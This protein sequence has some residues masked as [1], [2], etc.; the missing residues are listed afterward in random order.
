MIDKRRK[1][2]KVQRFSGH[3]QT[4]CCGP[5]DLAHLAASASGLSSSFHC[6]TCRFLRHVPPC[7]SSVPAFFQLLKMSGAPQSSSCTAANDTQRP[8]PLPRPHPEKAPS[9]G[10][11][12]ARLPALRTMAS[13]V[14]GSQ[15]Q[16]D[17]ALDH[18][19]FNYTLM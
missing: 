3:S 18:F 10:P 1:K 13:T 8:T 4:K 6:G 2:K 15:S 14:G 19:H 9:R 11:F 17:G 7:L 5:T 16:A 12:W